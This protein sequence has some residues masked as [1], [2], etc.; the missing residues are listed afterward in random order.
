MVV[1]AMSCS[2]ESV[3]A[4][5]TNETQMVINWAISAGASLLPGVQITRR[6]MT[7]N[8]TGEL[9]IPLTWK[10]YTDR[11]TARAGAGYR[12]T[13]CD[14]SRISFAR[15]A[16]GDAYSFEVVTLSAGPPLRARV[17]FAAMPD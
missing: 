13:F 2:H 5:L 9:S 10:E 17:I 8:A 1:L 6:G 11:L 15:V 4:K 7:V 16:G 3:D 14:R 12:M